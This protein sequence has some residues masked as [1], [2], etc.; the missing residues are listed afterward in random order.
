MAF[1]QSQWGPP[2]GSVCPCT[3]WI[4]WLGLN[5]LTVK[6]AFKNL[7]LGIKGIL[8]FC[9][10]KIS[11]SPNKHVWLWPSRAPIHLTCTNLIPNINTLLLLHQ[12]ISSQPPKKLRRVTATSA[13]C[14]FSCFLSSISCH[15]SESRA[16]MFPGE[17]LSV[18]LVPFHRK[19]SRPAP[20][21]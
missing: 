7:Q 13:K 12:Q 20:A 19:S 10:I 15:G 17:G 2:G 3:S 16:Q 11:F 1:L 8:V 6:R 14:S 4:G 5:Y 18:G 9:L 21:H